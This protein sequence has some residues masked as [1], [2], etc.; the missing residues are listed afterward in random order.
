MFKTHKY[1]IWIPMI[2]ILIA[3]ISAG[4][5]GFT[6]NNVLLAML[7]SALLFLIL[8]FLAN[9]LFHEQLDAEIYRQIDT[10]EYQ[11]NHGRN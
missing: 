7:V 4:I 5:L 1:R 3:G 11:K 6:T 8:F 2:C 10:E 9:T